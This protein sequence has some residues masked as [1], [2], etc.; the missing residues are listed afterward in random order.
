L[1]WIAE[2]WSCETEGEI[3]REVMMKDV[4]DWTKE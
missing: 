3:S 1:D 4:C 2:N